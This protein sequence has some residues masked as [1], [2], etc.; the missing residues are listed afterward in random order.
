MQPP[1][2]V[3][4]LATD[5]FAIGRD[6]TSTFRQC[7][8]IAARAEGA[9]FARH[10][11]RL[12]AAVRAQVAHHMRDFL[13]HIEIECVALVGPA[14]NKPRDF[15]FDAEADSLECHDPALNCRAMILR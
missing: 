9:A 15:V 2:G 10:H 8:Q 3:A 6:R 5:A 11:E 1:V 4:S 7:P 12:G 14:E 13:T